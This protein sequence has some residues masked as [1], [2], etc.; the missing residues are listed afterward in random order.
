MV[1]RVINEGGWSD[2]SVQTFKICLREGFERL[3]LFWGSGG[4]W[5][6]SQGS[7]SFRRL[8]PIRFD[9]N[10]GCQ[11]KLRISVEITIR[12][13]DKPS[14]AGKYKPGSSKASCICFRF[15]SEEG[16]SGNVI[17]YI[18]APSVS[19]KAMARKTVGRRPLNRRGFLNLVVADV[20]KETYLITMKRRHWGR[21]VSRLH[22]SRDI[23]SSGKLVIRN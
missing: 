8:F 9:R 1:E 3:P 13:A 14:K 2:A 22:A 20:V 12:K 18:N 7:C 4:L 15:N 5:W 23:R 21:R 11:L 10:W 6:R 19:R 16:C 17:L